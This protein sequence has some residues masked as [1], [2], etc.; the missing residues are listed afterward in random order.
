MTVGLHCRLA[1]PGRVSGLQE[2]LAFAKT[3]KDVWFCTREEIADFW[4]RNHYPVGEGSP[5]K[6]ERDEVSSEGKSEEFSVEPMNI[7]GAE[8]EK[9]KKAEEGGED[10]EEGDII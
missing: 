2:F 9:E 10:E 3:Y 8:V 4:E 1:H 5:M 7:E 6:S